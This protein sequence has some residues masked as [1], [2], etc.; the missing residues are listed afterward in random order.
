MPRNY[1][2]DIR[3]AREE[4]IEDIDE[5]RMAPERSIR[6]IGPSQSR[7]RL[8]RHSARHVPPHERHHT[9]PTGKKGKWGVWLAAGI[10]LVILGGAAA[11]ILFPSTSVAVT[12]HTQV[13][14]FDSST[15]FTAYP[16]TAAAPNTI[17]YSVVSQVFEDSTVVAASGI[18][19]VDEKATGSVTIYNEYSDKPVRLIKNTRF[20]AA[21]GLIYRIP[22]SVD[23]PGKTAAGPGTIQVTLFADQTGDT[24]NLP[25]QDRLTVPG[26]KSTPDMYNG[27]YAKSTAP[28]TG[29]FSGDRPAVAPATLDAARSEVRG[30]LN[31]KAQQLA[32]TA[33][34]GSIAF[35]G[36]A[37]ISFESLAPTQESGGGVRI[38]EK[39]TVVMPVFPIAAFAQAIGQAVS[40]SAEGQAL[41]IRFSPNISGSASTTL[42]LGEMGQKPLI[43]SLSGTGQLIWQV[44]T[45]GLAQALAGKEESSFQP[46]IQGFPSVEEARARITPFWQKSFPQ[47]PA[48]IQIEI[49]DPPQP[50]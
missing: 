4:S 15:S 19:R 33:P 38:H 22:A 32:A 35:P 49:Q 10:S 3:P 31:E 26:L 44:D 2:Q 46:I 1:R 11:L 47:D 41:D 36:L 34:E 18:E 24:Y 13:I 14:P 43:F 29:G 50:F 6:N 28:F 25:P 17:K 30:R 42:A 9:E 7:V 40:A 48:K 37:N 12:P 39:A 45:A 20:Q 5:P 27:V 21:N 8:Q 16:D 23:V